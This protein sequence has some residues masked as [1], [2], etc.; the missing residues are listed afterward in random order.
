KMFL[1]RFHGMMIFLL[2]TTHSLTNL[3]FYSLFYGCLLDRTSQHRRDDRPLFQ[4]TMAVT[5]LVRCSHLV[6]GEFGVTSLITPSSDICYTTDSSVRYAGFA[7][8]CLYWHHLHFPLRGW[9]HYRM[10]Y[11]GS[12]LWHYFNPP[13]P[14]PPSTGSAPAV[15]TGGNHGD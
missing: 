9:I 2:I 14:S 1:V 13:L 6:C 8:L 3:F 12:V 7:H 11:R 4:T 15:W 10:D 5:F